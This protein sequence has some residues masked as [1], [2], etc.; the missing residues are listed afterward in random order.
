M[1]CPRVPFRKGFTLIELLV[2]IA[3]IAILI[4]LLL[5][6]VQKIREAANRMSCTNNLK[7][8]GLA[9]HNYDSTY[10]YLPPAYIGPKPNSHYSTWTIDSDPNGSFVTS[11]TLLLPFVEQDNIYR[12]L[13]PVSL[14]VD[15]VTPGGYGWWSVDVGPWGQGNWAMAQTKIKTFICPSDGPQARQNAAALMHTYAPEGDSVGARGIVMY[16]FPGVNY[17]GKTNYT[18]VMGACGAN[19]AVSSSSDGGA[20]LRKYEG[21]FTNRS[22]NPLGAVPDGTSNTLLFGEGLGGNQ[23]DQFYWTWAG[24]GGMM[25]KFGIPSDFNKASYNH[26]SSKHPGVVNFCFGDGSV[27]PVRPGQTM[28]R[29]PPSQDW[30]TLQALA[31]MSDGDVVNLSSLSN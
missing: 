11:L 23:T 3:I 4:G 19:A 9:A 15:T 17:L 25:T 24:T 30:L 29:N 6:A 16:Y 20:N 12:Q 28:Q 1:S 21:L 13:D 18:A 8:L 2:V 26:F 14:N 31:G 22:K 7:Q 5:P 10:G 27:R